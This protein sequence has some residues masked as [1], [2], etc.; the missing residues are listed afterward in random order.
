MRTTSSSWAQALL[1]MS[2]AT[3]QAALNL[4]ETNVRPEAIGRRIQDLISGEVY[5]G[6]LVA[7]NAQN[8]LDANAL[9]AGIAQGQA[10][11]PAPVTLPRA[12]SLEALQTKLLVEAHHPSTM[13]LTA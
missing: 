6:N 11:G 1:L 4:H 2:A 3:T 10:K 9:L 13:S 7:R 5:N 12:T 8:G